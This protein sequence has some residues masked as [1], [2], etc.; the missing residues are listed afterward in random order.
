MPTDL[1]AA[2][3][4]IEAKRAK[5]L[6]AQRKQTESQ[7]TVAEEIEA[8]HLAAEEARLDAEL[9]QAQDAA[10]LTTVREANSGTLENAK[11]ALAAYGKGD[12]KLPADGSTL[13]KPMGVNLETGELL[14]PKEAEKA[15]T[16]DSVD[17]PQGNAASRKGA[18]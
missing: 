2:R 14:P 4:R 10:K 11:R 17:V 12:V 16:E 5:L 3:A 8:A 6:D 7:Q 1:D 13:E 15:L 9:S 18:R